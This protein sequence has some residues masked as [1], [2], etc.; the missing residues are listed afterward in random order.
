MEFIS[1]ADVLT[2]TTVAHYTR[3]SLASILSSSYRAAM[4][5]QISN[6]SVAEALSEEGYTCIGVTTSPQA[7]ETFGFDAGFDYHDNY[8]NPTGR[9]TFL[10]QLAYKIDIAGRT[11][12]RLFPRHKR[13]SDVP[14][15]DEIMETAIEEFNQA[16]GPRFLWMHFMESHRPYG[17]GD[18]AISPRLDRK[19]KYKT[20]RI[21]D[22]EADRIDAAYRDSLGRVD[23]W[24]ER[25]LDEL[26][27]EDPLVGFAGD[28]GEGLGEN[29]Y[30]FHPPHLMQTDD[31][32]VT[33]P[34][35]FK[36]INVEVDDSWVSLL[37]L[38]PTLLGG[39]GIEPPEEW[40]GVN[41]LETT[42]EY[43]ITIAPWADEATITWRTD[44]FTLSSQAGTASLTDESGTAHAQEADV[45]DEMRKQL[46][47]LGY[48]D[49]G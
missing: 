41:L 4:Q 35:V 37:D 40:H 6:P 33:V 1:S 23:G 15:D 13:R 10:Q 19:A 42:R 9:G 14:R 31:E 48:M 32:L 21:A 44:E 46:R 43:A 34:V 5:T 8:T 27:T 2:G 16:D 28:H 25:L 24:I 49:A 3:P 36:G 7:D 22:D 26:D 29:G 11:F 20:E 18:D 12:H 17:R 30:Y 45:S 47:D 39:A 38:A